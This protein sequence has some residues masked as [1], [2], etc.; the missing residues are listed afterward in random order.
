MKILIEEFTSLF[1]QVKNE[2]CHFNGGEVQYKGPDDPV[3][4][5]DIK[6]SKLFS[7]YCKTRSINFLSE[8]EKE[9]KIKPPMIII[10]PIDGTKEFVRKI[11]EYS[12]SVAFLNSPLIGD[13]HNWG[14]IYNP[15]FVPQM[16][17]NQSDKLL[18]LISRTEFDKKLFPVCENA[19]AKL[20]PVG[21]IAF[22][23]F[24]L[25]IGECD[26]VIS[27]KPKNIWDIAAGTI[28]CNQKGINFY[29]SGCKIENFNNILYKNDLIWCREKDLNE[30]KL[31]LEIQ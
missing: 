26:F 6:I 11:P 16:Q 30:I 13:I 31:F 18:G 29:S 24:L 27:K 25:S 10:D 2:L 21:S 9:Q 20:I 4:E 8:E 12:C 3:T 14:W 23:L 15:H 1:E 19:K 17:K 5:L 7:D 22:K 28:L